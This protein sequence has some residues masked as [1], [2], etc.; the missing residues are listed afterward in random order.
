MDIKLPVRERFLGAGLRHARGQGVH[1][2]V[3]DQAGS[4]V[5]DVNHQSLVSLSTSRNGWTSMGIEPPISLPSGEYRL[6]AEC[7]LKLH[8]RTGAPPVPLSV[9]TQGPLTIVRADEST[10]GLLHDADAG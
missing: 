9:R 1:V 5:A 8:D 7:E 2:V 10:V 4:I 3:R 6:E